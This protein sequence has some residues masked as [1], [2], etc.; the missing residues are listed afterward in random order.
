MLLSGTDVK[1]NKK[2]NNNKKQHLAVDVMMNSARSFQ[3]KILSYLCCSAIM[4]Y[5][6]GIQYVRFIH[7]LP[8]FASPC[9]TFA[10]T[11]TSAGVTD[12]WQHCV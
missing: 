2:N 8:L 4:L 12:E 10:L 7:I 9:N 6:K 5:G 3:S 11:V 1:K